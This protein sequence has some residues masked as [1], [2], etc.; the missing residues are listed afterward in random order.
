MVHM[1][2]G[3]NGDRG[4]H[5]PL[6]NSTAMKTS[7]FIVLAGMCV[8]ASQPCVGQ[9][10]SS[11]PPWRYTLLPD[12]QLVDDC[13]CGR[14]TLSLPLRG[15]F[16]LRFLDQSPLFTRYTVTN[17][18]FNT[19]WS[20]RHYHLSGQGLYTSGGEVALVQSL[21]LELR[22][23]NGFTNQLCYLTNDLP[24]VP[25]PW[26][27]LS[28]PL[29]Q[30]N[31]AI[32]QFYRINLVAA[33]FRELWF[34]TSHGMTP[35]T[36]SPPAAHISGGDL[37]SSSGGIVR[38]NQDLSARLGIMPMVPDLGLAALDVLPGGEFAFAIDTDVFSETL[39]MLS[40]GDLLSDHGRILYDYHDLL[41]TFSPASPDLSPGLDG[42]QFM[43]NGEVYFSVKRDFFSKTLQMSVGRGDLLS[44][45]GQ[46][47]THN[48]ALLRRFHLS[49]P[50]PDVGLRAFYLWPSGEVW[51][52]TEDG[53]PDA[54]LGTISSGDLLSDQ[55]YIVYR[56]LDLVAPFSPL[57]DLANFGLD[58]LFVIT[59]TTA[60]PPSPRFTRFG[61]DRNTGAF[62]LEWNN[63]GR[64]AQLQR[65][66]DA[67]GPWLPI[68]PI[69]DATN[70]SRTLP[71]APAQS[72]YRIQTW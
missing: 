37:L 58:A 34:S 5:A 36:P 33:P 1:S 60:P 71:A 64:L 63:P 15:T 49:S 18:D 66:T 38:L 57:E 7:C 16:D 12:S 11:P 23:D 31:G 40:D 67:L 50:T 42:I 30:T 72:F 39:G 35:G 10:P 43:T 14:P 19:S 41:Q 65:A 53:F 46:I 54:L 29:T 20:D 56:N 17:I 22:I 4:S 45:R 6:A 9:N 27:M 55:G 48:K 59:D 24:T 2:E 70:Y 21:V 8:A 26:P 32:I 47:V 68:L 13:Y 51:F 69:G 25:R 44:S 3:A 61:L 52:A 62:Q 28:V